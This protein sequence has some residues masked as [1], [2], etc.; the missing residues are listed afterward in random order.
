MYHYSKL[1]PHR[2]LF[3]QSN[4]SQS[5]QTLLYSCSEKIQ[6][7]LSKLMKCTICLSVFTFQICLTLMFPDFC[8]E[9][10]VIISFFNPFFLFCIAAPQVQ[11]KI[12]IILHAV[13]GA[14]LCL[15]PRLHRHLCHDVWLLFW[16]LQTVNIR[17]VRSSI[18]SY[19]L[20]LYLFI[21]ISIS[22]NIRFV[23]S[24][25]SSVYSGLVLISRQ[26]THKFLQNSSWSAKVL[27]GS[28]SY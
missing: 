2:L 23:R 27:Q 17:F 13:G 20:Y 5:N 19:C 14:L 11:P 12:Q 24:S 6:N 9:D 22:T 18:S 21:S 1:F 28:A 15:L 4:R 8:V 16:I 25:M 3:I 10:Q 7:N 26:E